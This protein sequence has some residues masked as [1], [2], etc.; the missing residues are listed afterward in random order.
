MTPANVK[1]RQ[2]RTEMLRHGAHQMWQWS[3]RRSIYE[4]V[5][6]K[7]CRGPVVDTPKN[8]S[9]QTLNKAREDRNVQ[10]RFIKITPIRVPHAP[11]APV[12][13][14]HAGIAAYI[15]LGAH[16]NRNRDCRVGCPV[17]RAQRSEK[18]HASHRVRGHI[19]HGPAYIR[20][21]EHDI[22]NSR[23]M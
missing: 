13:R 7:V 12:C 16:R 20:T 22:W 3:S 6:A 2:S 8:A 10:L 15:G 14:A 18:E 23:W 9:T 19:R 11:E 17:R 5:H 1:W 4:L 21:G